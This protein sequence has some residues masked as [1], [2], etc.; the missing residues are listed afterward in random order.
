MK[1]PKYKIRDLVKMH[2]D[3][4]STFHILEVIINICEGGSRISYLVRPIFGRA[5][6]TTPLLRVGEMEIEAQV[7][8]TIIT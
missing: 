6:L 3:T 4:E 2:L 1:E 5:A 8:S 7:G